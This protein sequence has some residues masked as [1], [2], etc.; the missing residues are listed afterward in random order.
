MELGLVQTPIF[1][2]KWLFPTTCE[3]SVKI[4]GKKFVRTQKVA[5]KLQQV[6]FVFICL[7]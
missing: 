1:G 2:Q 4:S 3:N 7:G 6:V 5:L